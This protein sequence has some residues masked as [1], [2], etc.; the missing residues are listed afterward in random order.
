MADKIIELLY[1]I[2]DDEVW[3]LFG[4]SGYKDN[5]P[6]LRKMVAKRYEAGFNVLDF[7][8]INLIGGLLI[9]HYIGKHNKT[10]KIT[11]GI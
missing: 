10:P 6:G 1:K 8:T 11:N 2:T 5:I 3:L 9:G 7:G 4:E